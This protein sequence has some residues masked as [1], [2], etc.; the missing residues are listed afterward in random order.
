M[1]ITPNI[2]RA[3]F[4]GFNAAFN[5]GAKNAVTNWEKIATEVESSSASNTYGWLG[6]FPTFREWIGDRVLKDISAHGYVVENK[7]YESSIVVPRTDIEDDQVGVYGKL[8]EEMGRAAVVHGDELIFG[9]L[10]N[11]TS[12]KC[13]DGKNFF[14]TAHPVGETPA[15]VSNF[16][17]GDGPAWYLLDV[18]RALKPLL[19]QVRRKYNLQA[20][21]SP[22]DE[23][24]FMRDEYRYGVDARVNA[25]F[26]FW[27]FA[28]C[29]KAPLTPENYEAARAAML[30]YKSDQGRPLGVI[31][32][33]LVVPSELEGKAR[34]LVVKDA[35]DGN[36]WAGSADV[37]VSPWLDY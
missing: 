8:F 25:G 28:Y 1:L 7:K 5:T 15:P 31:P 34:T 2:L 35:N 18:S 23:M 20:V 16:Q 22:N 13:Y 37:L 21:N 12:Q 3:L 11:G 27:Q 29:S 32:R 36:P 24:V 17:D 26:G 33:L 9:L 6:Q 10:K 4:T 19:F 30:K 14:D